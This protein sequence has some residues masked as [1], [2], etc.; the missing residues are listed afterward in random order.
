MKTVEYPR[1]LQWVGDLV[2]PQCNG[3][4][5]AWQSSGMSQSFPHFYCDRCS[6]VLLRPADQAIVWERATEDELR[7]IEAT[8]PPCPCGGQF[9]PGANPKC[10]H[11][12]HEVPHQSTPVERLRDPHMIVTDGSCVYRDP[13]EPYRVRIA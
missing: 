10:Q 13:E 2:C 11:C 8:L 3:L 12:G 6:D 7:Q 1:S 4:T 5:P 9:R